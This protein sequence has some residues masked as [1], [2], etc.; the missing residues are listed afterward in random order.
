MTKRLFD[1]V[2]AALV[3]LLLSPLF[4]VIALWIVSDSPGPVFFRQTRVGRS[5][6]HFRIFKFRTMRADGAGSGLPLT[7]GADPRITRAGTFLRRFKLDELPQFINVL[8]G[9]MSIVG[10]RPE[11]PKYVELY[12]PET[13][14]IVLSVRPGITDP[15]SIK[16]SSE[17]AILGRSPNPE[18]TY[19]NEIMP[20]KLQLCVEY[21]QHA[22]L[23]RDLTIVCDTVR[24]LLFRAGG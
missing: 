10:P 15:A 21:V 22:G 2:V 1:I 12:P 5:G 17:S 6:A 9:Q 11:V 3:L 19:V 20:A 8:L 7:I 14:N 4:A 18:L 13:R 24:A 23:W 16:F